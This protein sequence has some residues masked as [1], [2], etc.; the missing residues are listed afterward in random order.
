M[1]EV[2]D[3]LDASLRQAR[4][5]A[6]GFSRL[7]QARRLDHLGEHE[8][9]RAKKKNRSVTSIILRPIRMIDARST[10]LLVKRSPT[11]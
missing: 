10:H 6:C 5:V 1:G 2:L 4:F 3:A 7:I 11:A 9:P 8:V